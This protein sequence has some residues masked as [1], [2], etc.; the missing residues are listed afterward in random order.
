MKLQSKLADFWKKKL[1]LDDI[2]E[3][4]SAPCGLKQYPMAYVP[5]ALAC[6]DTS[7][8]RMRYS[9][10]PRTKDQGII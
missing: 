10:F 4:C 3:G 8:G 5:V 9:M 7:K 2:G 6:V 1:V